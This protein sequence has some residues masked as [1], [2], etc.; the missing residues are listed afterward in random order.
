MHPILFFVYH[1][2]KALIEVTRRVFYAKITVVNKER[3]R[4]KEPCILVSNHPSTLLDPLNAAEEI[5]TEVHFLANASLFKNLVAAWFFKKL[6]CIPIERYEDTGGKPLNNKASFE[7]A[8]QHLE[9]G[10]CLYIAPEGTSYIHRRLRKL[11]TGSARIA[12]AAESQANFQLGLV[13]LPVGLN[14]SD[15]TQFRSHLLT[16]LGEPIRVADFEADWKADEAA[17]VR[18]LTDH[19][20]EK[21]S[22]LLLDTVD[23]EE[24]RLLCYLEEMQQNENRLPSYPH[25]LRSKKTLAAIQGWSKEVPSML[26]TF[27]T[28]VFSY[29][30]TL[31]KLGVSDLA[32][33]EQLKVKKLNGSFLALIGTFPF[34]LLGYLTHFLPAYSTGK[35]SK[36]LNKDIHWAPTYKYVIG[37]VLYPLMLGFQVWVA[38]KFG[39][40]PGTGISIKW[41]YALS[42]IPAGLVAEWW[43]KTWKLEREKRRAARCFST[44]PESWK[45]IGAVRTSIL[46]ILESAPES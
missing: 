3:G 1:F 40:L 20:A 36:I 8:V 15:P 12:L 6:F 38:G 33:Y 42:I 4:F 9:H 5:Q 45:K 27:Q 17:A 39:V 34:F 11:K 22:N 16:I 25:F 44:E 13:L 7:K 19:L 26:A 2:F 32:V 28:N 21:L 14:Y 24:D 29:F 18:K 41:L 30:Q 23:D 35:L 31:E 10:G 37:V 43:L 46:E